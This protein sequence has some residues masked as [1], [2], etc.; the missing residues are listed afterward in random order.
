MYIAIYL[1]MDY[2][3]GIEDLLSCTM[4]EIFKKEI[5]SYLYVPG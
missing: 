5:K 1:S 4:I 3:Q 2:K